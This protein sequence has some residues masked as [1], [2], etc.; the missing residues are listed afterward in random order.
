LGYDTQCI[1]FSR[2][3]LRKE[4]AAAQNKTPKEGKSRVH[5]D[6]DKKQ[7]LSK[8][9]NVVYP[10]TGLKKPS[11]SFSPT[12]DLAYAFG[13]KEIVV[14]TCSIKEESNNGITKRKRRSDAGLTILIPISNKS[15]C[16]QRK[17]TTRRSSK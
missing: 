3:W 2:R 13:V 7:L 5:L 4:E 14:R 10:L 16:V 9:R 8:I 11:R 12:A 6:A 17:H 15:K 1:H